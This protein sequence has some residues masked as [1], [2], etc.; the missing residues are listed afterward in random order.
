[1]L[2]RGAGAEVRAGDEDRRAGVLGLVEDEVGVVP[3]LG[4]QPRAEA[5]ALDALQPLAGDD[6]VGVDVGAVERDGPPGDDRGRGSIRLAP[7]P[8]LAKRPSDGGGS[9]HGRRDEVRAPAAALAALE[10]AVRGGGAALARPRAGRGSSPRHIEQPGSRHSKPARSKILSRPSASACA[11]TRREPGTTS[12]RRP[13]FTCAPV[14][15][16]RG[17]PAGPRSASSCRSR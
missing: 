17:A 5:G 15:R 10:V 13:A 6:L 1:M 14:E 3:P 9:G 7:R 8:A 12:A 11:F 2:A 4:E 16:R